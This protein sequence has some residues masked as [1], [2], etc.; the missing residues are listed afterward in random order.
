MLAR[1]VREYREKLGF[2]QEELAEVSG[3]HRTYISGIERG[4]RN[5]TISVVA[6]LAKALNISVSALLS[7]AGE[8]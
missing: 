3:L 6:V 7:K 4:V 8:K 1:N 5:P 2:S